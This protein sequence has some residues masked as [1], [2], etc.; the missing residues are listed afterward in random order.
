MVPEQLGQFQEE[1]IVILESQSLKTRIILLQD[2]KFELEISCST[3]RYFETVFLVM[4]VG[5]LELDI[6]TLFVAAVRKES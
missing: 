3:Q 4:Q 6:S 2:N 1:G 5:K